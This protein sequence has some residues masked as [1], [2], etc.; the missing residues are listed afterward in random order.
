MWHFIDKYSCNFLWKIPL[1]FKDITKRKEGIMLEQ[2]VQAI[3]TVGFPIIAFLLIFWKF[4]KSLGILIVAVNSNT[5]AVQLLLQK[6]GMGL[7][8]ITKK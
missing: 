1:I 7:N 4:D 2:I 5:Q 8:E 6:E 3:S